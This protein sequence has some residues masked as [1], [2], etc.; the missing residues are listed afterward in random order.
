V[1]TNLERWCGFLSRRMT[2]RRPWNAA[3][4]LNLFVI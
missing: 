3:F 4:P 1:S 2:T